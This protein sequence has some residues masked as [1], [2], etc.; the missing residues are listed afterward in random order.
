MVHPKSNPAILVPAYFT[1]AKL[2]AL[3]DVV[4]VEPSFDVERVVDVELAVDVV[5][6][7]KLVDDVTVENVVEG[8]LLAGVEGLEI[9]EET[10]VELAD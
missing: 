9:D 1:C 5:D 10:T 8:R 7:L 6:I 4:D 3:V 2:G